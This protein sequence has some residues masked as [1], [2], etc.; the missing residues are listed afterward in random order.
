M[1][2][3]API[4][5]SMSIAFLPWFGVEKLPECSYDIGSISYGL[6]GAFKLELLAADTAVNLELFFETPL[7]I[8]ITQEGSLMDYW[9]SGFVVQ[10][11][12]VFVTASSQFLD[13]LEHSSSGVHSVDRVKHFAVFTDD[14]CVEVLSTDDP[15]VHA[16]Q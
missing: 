1:A 13:W 2:N 5:Q 7:A 14:V 4:S 10:R 11:H 15:V 6:D 12:N 16:S 9:N 3:N 8:R